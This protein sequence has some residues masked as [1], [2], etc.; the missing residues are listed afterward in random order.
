VLGY[1][2]LTPS[3]VNVLRR[4]GVLSEGQL[5]LAQG[6]ARQ[7]VDKLQSIEREAQPIIQDDRLSLEQK[8][9]AIARMGYNQRLM[10][11]VY[12]SQRS[13]L[14]A[15]QPASYTGFVDWI[16]RR[17]LVERQLHGAPRVPAGQRTYEVFATR[18]DSKGA[19]TVALPDKC[20]KFANAGNHI[21]DG[22]GYS[23]GAGYSVFL[24]YTSGVGAVVGE[25]G[26]WNVDD[27]YWARANDPQ[28][29][30]LFKDLPLGMPEAQAA[31][32]NNYNGGQDQFGRKVTAPFGIDLA[33]QVSIDIGLQ[34]G[35]NDWINVS[36]MWTEGWDGGAV[37][38]TPRPGTPLA[39]EPTLEYISPVETMSPQEDGSI[40]HEVQPGQALWSI[41]IA[42][43]VTIK[44][45]QDLNGLSDSSLILPGQKL[46]IRPAGTALPGSEIASTTPPAET[47]QP[48][49]TA[50]LALV[51]QPEKAHVSTGPA[52]LE[53]PAS[54]TPQFISPGAE[55]NSGVD[56]YLIVI[57]TLL[58]MGIGLILAGKAMARKG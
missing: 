5:R 42:Y 32:F 46:V 4:D 55:T 12:D 24:S 1:F 31:Y 17:W 41:A 50:E 13:L 48:R 15:L 35:V 21:C 26:P 28:P 27:N 33:R 43:Q 37:K 19:Y 36:F 40:V 45:I 7:E 34:P 10:A 39:L 18:Y 14:A 9:R 25:S 54:E 49:K 8:R 57:T 11:V 3:L 47:P 23:A 29:R 2:L 38:K 58:V 30:R 16:E 52:R 53:I 20:L 6:I 44:S 51:T 56:P 22:D